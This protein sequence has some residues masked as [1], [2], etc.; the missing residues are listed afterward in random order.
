MNSIRS[1]GVVV[2]WLANRIKT[3]APPDQIRRVADFYT[4]IS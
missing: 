4:S 2:N 3:N 1:V